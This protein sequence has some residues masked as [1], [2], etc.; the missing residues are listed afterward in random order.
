[1]SNSKNYT[2]TSIQNSLN[3]IDKKVFTEA[4]NVRI[5]NGYAPYTVTVSKDG[6]DENG[7]EAPKFPYGRYQPFAITYNPFGKY[8]FNTNPGDGT[9]L[10]DSGNSLTG[11]L[12]AAS[13]SGGGATTTTS[14]V[15][16]FNNGTY[17]AAPLV[18][19]HS[20]FFSGG[21]GSSD[22]QNRK[23]S[24]V[25]YE[26]L[27]SDSKW[28]ALTGSHSVSMWMYITFKNAQNR[29][30]GLPQGLNQGST[31]IFGLTTNPKVM[32]ANLRSSASGSFSLQMHQYS[33]D[34]Y[35]Q[36]PM[37]W[38][39]RDPTNH[40]QITQWTYYWKDRD[41]NLQPYFTNN[42]WNHVMYCVSGAEGDGD[43]GVALYINGRRLD[44]HAV[45]GRN[46][47]PSWLTASADGSLLRFVA[48]ASVGSTNNPEFPFLGDS[49]A[50]SGYDSHF[51]GSFDQVAIWSQYL[52]QE[53]V[54]AIYEASGTLFNI[55]SG[56]RGIKRKE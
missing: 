32:A 18:G 36:G 6:S 12:S 3:Q 24:Y 2:I 1:M 43:R 16:I 42:Q 56:L 38:T 54:T 33:M 30:A 26:H 20:L 55:D 13:A 19:A 5:R 49:V 47:Y 44:A 22:P 11:T 23:C 17:G 28:K 52:T 53:N 8:T 48:T 7:E 15:P 45:S 50:Y 41:N 10:D 40:A 39:F 9:V 46:S 37:A 34:F 21:L 27:V 4:S 35:Q 25:L 29:G 31:N 14:Q 51:T